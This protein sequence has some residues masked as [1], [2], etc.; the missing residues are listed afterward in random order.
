ML[1]CKTNYLFVASG[2][3]DV[4]IFKF[5]IFSLEKTVAALL[6]TEWL[7]ILQPLQSLRA[8][9]HMYAKADDVK[10]YYFC[11]SHIQ[12][13]TTTH[14]YSAAYKI[15]GKILLGKLQS[16]EKRSPLSFWNCVIRYTHVSARWMKD[17]W[18]EAKILRQKFAD[19]IEKFVRLARSV[20][21]M[22]CQ[23][24]PVKYLSLMPI[25][26]SMNKCR[27][28]SFPPYRKEIATP[29]WPWLILGPYFQK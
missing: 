21:E 2:R 11:L 7:P 3:W 20:W 27:L 17:L 12:R 22:A 5:I 24:P 23:Q 28:T 1:G 9:I 14:R 6:K 4:K 18:K 26:A 19:N 15:D 25:R 29:S 16:T 13:A 8:I 10:M